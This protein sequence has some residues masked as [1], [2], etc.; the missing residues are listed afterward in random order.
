MVV[1]EYVELQRFSNVIFS[2]FKYENSIALNN[3]VNEI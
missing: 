1:G 3:V 2:Q